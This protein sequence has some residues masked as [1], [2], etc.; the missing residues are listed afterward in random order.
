MDAI[1]IRMN[2]M[3]KKCL[4][5]D[6]CEEKECYKNNEEKKCKHWKRK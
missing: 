4:Y 1:E 5:N 2:K 6:L 3:R